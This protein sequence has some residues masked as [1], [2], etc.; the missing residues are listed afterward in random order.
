MPNPAIGDYIVF[1]TTFNH[2]SLRDITAGKEYKIE[3]TVPDA[4]DDSMQKPYIID[5]SG[6]ENAKALEVCVNG[7]YRIVRKASNDTISIAVLEPDEFVAV[8]HH[9]IASYSTKNNT[10]SGNVSLTVEGEI[11]PR[12]VLADLQYA[13]ATEA[14]SGIRDIV[15]TGI[16]KL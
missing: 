6:D 14:L 15:I 7:E 4:Y 8:K 11:N 13:A 5:D 12:T 9:Y 16:F 2:P 3:G 10:V 1:D